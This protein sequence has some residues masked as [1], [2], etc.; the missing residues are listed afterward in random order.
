M[1]LGSAV[2]ESWRFPLCTLRA[3]IRRDFFSSFSSITL[4]WGLFPWGSITSISGQHY[5]DR[6]ASSFWGVVDTKISPYVG[7]GALS[8]HNAVCLTFLSLGIIE[9]LC[10]HCHHHDC[11]TDYVSAMKRLNSIIVQT[12]SMHN[13]EVICKNSFNG[14]ISSPILPPVDICGK[15]LRWTRRRA[16]KTEK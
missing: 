12:F 2:A 1:S 5:I 14:K 9:E 3:C 4:H 10:I 11:V 6:Y 16:Q 8:Q 15:R 13:R 7:P